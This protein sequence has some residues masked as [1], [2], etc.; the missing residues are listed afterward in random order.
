MLWHDPIPDLDNANVGI[1]DTW[2]ISRVGSASPYA[3]DFKISVI[4]SDG[5]FILPKQMKCPSAKNS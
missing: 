5:A 2:W 1:V 3:N 4:G